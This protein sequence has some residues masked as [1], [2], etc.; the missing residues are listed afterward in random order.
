MKELLIVRIKDPKWFNW[1]IGPV[2]PSGFVLLDQV[3]PIHIP[4]VLDQLMERPQDILKE[5]SRLIS[6]WADVI[7]ERTAVRLSAYCSNFVSHPSTKMPFISTFCRTA[8]ARTSA[9]STKR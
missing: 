6:A 3:D 1:L 7:S 2:K 9:A 4:S 8:I 5:S